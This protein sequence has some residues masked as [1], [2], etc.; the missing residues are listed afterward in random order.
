MRKIH[1][2]GDILTF[3]KCFKI[4]GLGRHAIECNNNV[5]RCFKYGKTSH[6]IIDCKSVRPTC[7]NYGEH[8]H[9]NTNCHKSKKARS[10]G[11]V[12]A[13]SRSETTSVGQLIWGMCFINSIPLIAI[14]DT[15]ATYSFVSLN[16][17]ERLGLDCLLQLRVSLLIPQS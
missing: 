13:L 15:G 6:W 7:Y 9:I 5:L 11:K 14:I 17:A 16:Y 12:F 2:G 1:V 3:V 10:G 8:G 4:G